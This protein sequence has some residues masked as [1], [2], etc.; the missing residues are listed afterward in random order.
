M[1]NKESKISENDITSA[2]IKYLEW[3]KWKVWRI[4]NGGIPARAIQNK[5]IYKKKE[6]KYRGVPDLFALKSSFPIL[7]LEIK[8]KGNYPSPEQKKFIELVKT[9]QNGWAEI[10]YSLNEVENIIKELNKHYK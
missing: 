1:K 6:E 3:N 9:S 5:I 10:V 8:A 7:F 2:I 4:Y